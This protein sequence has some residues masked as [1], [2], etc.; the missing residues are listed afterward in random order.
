MKPRRKRE[1]ARKP[2]KPATAKRKAGSRAPRAA[3]PRNVGSARA[4]QGAV[5]PALFQPLSEGEQAAALRILTEDR[6]LSHMAKVA[7]YRVVAVEPLVV[8]PPHPLFGQRTARVVI[9][10]YAS[11]RSVEAAVDLE[12]SA[13]AHLQIGS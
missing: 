7:R 10:D 3:A 6:R 11:D 4:R 12:A 9:Y 5:D 2:A 1:P 13:V 8:K